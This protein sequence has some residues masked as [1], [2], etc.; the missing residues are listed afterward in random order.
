M[1]NRHYGY[2]LTAQMLANPLRQG[3]KAVLMRTF[4]FEFPR[5]GELGG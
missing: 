1:S 2:L 5:K 3:F 4:S